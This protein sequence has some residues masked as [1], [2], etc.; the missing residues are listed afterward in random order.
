MAGSVER[1]EDNRVPKRM[2]YGRTEKE[3]R[4]IPAEVVRRCGGGL[5]RYE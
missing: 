5:E 2:L 3:E 1:M 4:K